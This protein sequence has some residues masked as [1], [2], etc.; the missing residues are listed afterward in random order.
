M[1]RLNAYIGMLQSSTTSSQPAVGTIDITR[2]RV[3]AAG[4]PCAARARRARAASADSVPL[5][6]GSAPLVAISAPSPAPAKI[7]TSIVAR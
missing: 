6:S 2:G 4:R 3:A 5:Y 7:S 1:I